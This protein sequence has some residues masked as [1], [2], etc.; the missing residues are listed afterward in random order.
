M[1]DEAK[2]MPLFGF[3]DVSVSPPSVQGLGLQLL[4]WVRPESEF[5]KTVDETSRAPPTRAHTARI[6]TRQKGRDPATI[7]KIVAA[8][9]QP[10][11][12]LGN[13]FVDPVYN[14]AEF[15]KSLSRPKLLGPQMPLRNPLL[16]VGDMLLGEWPRHTLFALASLNSKSGT[17]ASAE[18]RRLR[19][20]IRDGI[21]SDGF[22]TWPAFL[23]PQMSASKFIAEDTPRCFLHDRSS[24]G[25]AINGEVAWRSWVKANRD[26]FEMVTRSQ[27][28]RPRGNLLLDLSPGR[29]L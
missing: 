26:H 12:I 25:T 24:N 21:H 28:F 17:A 23:F 2:K 7:A 10:G 22:D 8:G 6:Y 18:V 19:V 1:E 14:R 13:E 27:Y 16:T 4:R 9:T 11:V 29:V 15:D 3:A 20:S 5:W